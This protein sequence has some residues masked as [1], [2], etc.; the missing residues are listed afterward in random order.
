SRR[1]VLDRTGGA[2]AEWF[3]LAAG[4]HLVCAKPPDTKAIAV[5][6]P[7]TH[8]ATNWPMRAGGN[9]PMALRPAAQH[10]VVVFRRPAKLGVFAMADGA[11][12]ASP[13]TCGDSDDVFDDAKRDRVYVSCGDG[14]I[15]VFDG[16][17]YRRL[18]RISTV[19]G[20][21]TS[22]FVPEAGRLFVAVRASWSERA[23]IWVFAPGS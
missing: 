12:V 14:S 4:S 3:R 7:A 16:K 21:R 13:D 18:A 15:D 1:Q 11:S 19:A 22:L 6:D 2:H 10:V 23:A 20:A 8:K 5:I 9:F 17:D